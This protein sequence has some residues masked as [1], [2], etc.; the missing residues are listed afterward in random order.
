MSMDLAVSREA[1]EAEPWPAFAL[2]RRARIVSVNGAWDRVATQ[3]NGPVAA[4][5]LET[6]WRDHIAGAELRAWYQQVFARVLQ[7]GVGES[8][9]GDCNTPDRYRLFSSCFE[10]LRSRRT[11][12]R[13]GVLVLTTLLVEAPIDEIYPI[14]RPDELRYL[15]PDGLIRQCSG[16]RRARIADRRRPSGTSY[17]S[18]SARRAATSLMA[19]AGSVASS[20]TGSRSTTSAD[21]GPAPRH[22]RGLAETRNARR[23]ACGLVVT[24]L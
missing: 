19:S 2:D 20:I 13:A 6:C 11:G 12:D 7:L 8:H 18:T 9:R 3:T 10:P 24:I 16:C 21:A 4:E 1:L 23:Y 5:V 22:H 17:R 14:D 15:C